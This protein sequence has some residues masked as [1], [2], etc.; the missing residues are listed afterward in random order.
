M[1][2]LHDAI[3]RAQVAQRQR[4][5]EVEI[6]GALGQSNSFIR[7]RA[8]AAAFSG[9]REAGSGGCAARSKSW[10]VLPGAIDQPDHAHGRVWL[11]ES[12]WGA[13]DPVGVEDECLKCGADG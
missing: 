9:S 13:A 5:E 11:P 8:C 4:G 2:R 3:A 7:T 10:L 6:L 12:H 1:R